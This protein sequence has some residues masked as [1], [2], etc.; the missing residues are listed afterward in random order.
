MM[1]ENTIS[2]VKTGLDTA[3]PGAAFA[4]GRGYDVYVREFMGKR[5]CEPCELPMT[6][7]TLFDIASLSKLVSTTMIALKL[8]ET[9]RL[10]PDDTIGRYLASAEK[11]GDCS[12][13]HLLTHTS[14]L[15]P[16]MPL[17]KMCEKGDVINTIL[18][19]EP[20]CG[21]GDEVHYSCMGYILLGHILE[22][23]GGK[24]LDAL[25]KAYVFEPIGMKTAC[26]CRGNRRLS[27]PVAATEYRDDLGAWVSGFVHDE[28]AYHL[29]GVAGNAGVF[30][31]LDDMIAFAGMS[32]MKGTLRNGEEYL[33]EKTFRNAIENK[34][35]DKVESRGYGFQL[36]GTQASPMG[37]KMSIGSYGHT[38]FTGTS[39]YVDRESGLWGILLTNSVHYGRN[40]RSAYCPLRRSFYD[41]IKEEYEFLKKKGKL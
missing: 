39:L 20:L 7:D 17:Y 30:A 15:V 18:S 3:Y 2:L 14:G 24:S 23:V 22:N 13:H 6:E 41:S 40:H 26:Y 21:V 8:I 27:A 9:G 25:A 16:H 11:Y 19:R 35:P 34:T 29:D 37:E 28:N 33:S 38:G 36:K 32:S 31:T 12:I 10:S 5:Q 1:F 4:V